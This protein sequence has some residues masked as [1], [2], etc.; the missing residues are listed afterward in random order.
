MRRVLIIDDE[1]DVAELMRLFLGSLGYEADVFLS[2]EK[3]MR[4]VEDSRYWAVFCDYLMPGTTG[5]LLY[6]QIRGRDGGLAKRFALITG[7]VLDEHLEEFLK[8]E[9]VKVI[10]KPFKLDEIKSILTEFETL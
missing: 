7:A 5:D 6:R 8:N 4:A 9:R 2:G 10:G 1:P 3:A